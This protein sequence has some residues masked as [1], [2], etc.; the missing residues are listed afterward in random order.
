MELREELFVCVL[1]PVSKGT[2]SCKFLRTTQY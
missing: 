2:R 1:C